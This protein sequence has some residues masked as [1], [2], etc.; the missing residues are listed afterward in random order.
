MFWRR[1]K[2][3]VENIDTKKRRIIESALAG[4]PI[5][6]ILNDEQY[7][8]PYTKPPVPGSE[9]FHL[10]EEKIIKTSCGQC[11]VG[12]GIEV[13]VVEGRAVKIS[14]NP[15]STPNRGVLG[16]KG[17]TGIFTL[18]DPD[19][20]KNPLIARTKREFKDIGWDEA[21]EEAAKAISKAKRIAILCGRPI[22]FSR[23]LFERFAYSIGTPLFYDYYDKSYSTKALKMAMKEATGVEDIPGYD[24]ENSNY[25][26]SLG[27]ALFEST[28]HGLRLSRASYKIKHGIPTIRAKIVQVEPFLSLTS[29]QADEWFKIRPGKYD[30]LALGIA[31]VLISEGL[32][33]KDIKNI[34]EGFDEF[35]KIV[36]NYSPKIVEK[37]TGVPDRDIVRIAKELWFSRPSIIVTD[38]RSTSTTNGFKIAYTA[39]CLSVLVGGINQPGGLY[40]RQHPKFKD[41]ENNPEVPKGERIP[42]YKIPESDVD[43]IILYYWNPLYSE[44]ACLRWE[45]I[46][47][48][49][50]VISFSPFMDESTALADLILP[51]HTFLE[52]FED[53]QTHSSVINP[54]FGIRQPV[55]APLYNTQNACDSLIKIARKLGLDFPWENFEEAIK[56]RLKD[57]DIE[58]IKEKG[59]FEGEDIA[60]KTPKFLF[61]KK[62]AL[63]EPKW[64]GEGDIYLLPYKSI[65][66][67]EGSGANIPYLQELG[68]MLR[69]IP[70]YKSYM[71]FLEISPELAEKLDVKDGDKVIVE[72]QI[73]EIE[74][75]VIIREGIPSDCALI[76]LGKGHKEYGRFAKDKGVNPRE[77]LLPVVGD[78]DNLS[79]WATKVKIKKHRGAK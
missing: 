63:E 35:S 8:L 67:A 16:P 75:A 15:I 2:N 12:C 10:G 31:N 58:E 30:I 17:L 61:P 64:E 52:R 21:I 50:F 76:E 70:S 29:K 72:S 69:K 46:L 13:R 47:K 41:W 44:P 54:S 25:I 9:D 26:L 3:K 59:W 49:S 77:I 37:E 38:E 39:L 11:H 45:R 14:G 56:E 79:H 48:N 55:V 4:F 32:Y 34:S 36:S 68:G 78:T 66:Y 60:V 43:L 42:F 73:G 24:F 57:Y 18:Y 33:Y 6:R 51:D 40:I 27:A 28:C 19:R 22:G 23:D 74:V 5:S 65:T 1:I 20:I 53:T 71:S 7:S 62:L